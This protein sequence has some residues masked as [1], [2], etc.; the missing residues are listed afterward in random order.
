[1]WPA[2]TTQRKEFCI[3]LWL[4]L[5]LWQF[6]SHVWVFSSSFCNN[7][8][9]PPQKKV[10]MLPCWHCSRLW[11]LNLMELGKT[12]R[13]YRSVV[14]R[15]VVL[16]QLVVCLPSSSRSG[17]NPQTSEASV[18]WLPGNSSGQGRMSWSVCLLYSLH[19]VYFSDPQPLASHTQHCCCSY[20]IHFIQYTSLTETQV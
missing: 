13:V 16:L 6:Q 5:S 12:V 1:M 4:R 3:I 11:G 10:I 17:L 15:S 18:T 9:P 14:Y 20:N 8:P 19:K 7:T 2:C